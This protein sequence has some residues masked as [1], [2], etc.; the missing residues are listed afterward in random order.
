MRSTREGETL[1]AKRTLRIGLYVRVSTDGQS[2][3]NQ[4][5]ELRDVVDAKG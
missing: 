1:N 2:A 4:Q 5:R 3:A